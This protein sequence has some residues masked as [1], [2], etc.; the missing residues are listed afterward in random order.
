MFDFMNLVVSF[1][2]LHIKNVEWDGDFLVISGD[3]WK[4]VTN[5]VWRISQGKELLFACWDDQVDTTIEELIGLSVVSMSWVN[6][7]QPIDPSFI[8]SDDRRLDVFCSYSSE[9]WVMDLPDNSV[10]VGNT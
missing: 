2:P 8:L 10:Y 6:N 9:P 3:N 4:F 5:S 1:A 7:D